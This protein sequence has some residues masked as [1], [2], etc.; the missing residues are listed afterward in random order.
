MGLGK[1]KIGINNGA[2]STVF[3]NHIVALN[4]LGLFR[5]CGFNVF[6]LSNFG[7][8]GSLLNCKNYKQKSIKF[9]FF[10]FIFSS[11]LSRN[12]LFIESII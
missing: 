11:L 3:L 12:F 8:R 10:S 5:N 7:S 2:G 9:F 4:S 6:G 1:S